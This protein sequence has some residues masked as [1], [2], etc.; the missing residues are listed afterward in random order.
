MLEHAEIDG[1]IRLR[2]AVRLHIRVLGSENLLGPV[3]GQLLDDIDIFAT[4][5]PTALAR[6]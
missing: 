1:R 6:P 4:A 3:D 5:I 2:T